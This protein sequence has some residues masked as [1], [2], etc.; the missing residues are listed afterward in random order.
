MLWMVPLCGDDKHRR[1]RTDP[2]I[3]AGRAST[4]RNSMRACWSAH[5]LGLDHAALIAQAE[6]ELTPDET[7]A[8]AALAARRLAREPVARILGTKEFWSLPLKLNAHTLVPR[9]ET[10]TVVEAALAALDATARAPLR[11][12]RSRHRIGRADPA[13]ALSE[14]PAAFGIGT[15]VSDRGARLRT[16]QCARA[17]PRRPARHSWPAI[18]APRLRGRSISSS[19]IR[20]ISRAT[21]SPALAPEVRPIRSAPR[22]RWRALMDLMAIARSPPMR[23][24]C[25]RRNGI[26]VV[27]IGR[28]PGR[29]GE[30]ACSPTP[31]WHAGRAR[32]VRPGGVR[33]GSGHAPRAMNV[34]HCRH[35]K[36][37][38]DCGAR[39][40][41]FPATEST[42]DN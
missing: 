42:R 17:R 9:P 41:R 15:D 25:S 10:E 34:P 4:R 21:K 3:S 36:K 2:S 37:H 38:L 20:P 12:A 40:T 28:G 1:R 29:C 35:E 5:A 23:G 26:L 33:P 16:R 30:F 19:P 14:L 39:P 18:T 27:E 7:D 8:I 31:A 24:A 13:R 6:R 32:T 22:T 11:V